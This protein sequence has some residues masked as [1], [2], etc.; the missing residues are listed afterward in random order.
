LVFRREEKPFGKSWE[1]WTALWWKWVLSK[2]KSDNPGIDET[3][4][5]FT[6]DRSNPYVVFMVGTFG[7]HSER[8][9]VLPAGM[10]ILFP[11]INFTTSYKE[12]PQL[13]SEADL[14]ARAKQDIDDIVNKE[15][16]IN[17]WRLKCL[18]KYRVQSQ[19]FDLTLPEDNVFGLEHG[20]T[21]AVSDGYWVFLK[22]LPKGNYDIHASGSCSLGKTKVDILWH[23]LAT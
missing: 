6:T 8:R 17:G 10:A 2:P 13:K 12:E 14:L 18:E 23:V 19:V 20:P 11:I 22:P 7:G 3:G 5:K 4:E 21:K 15:A 9:Y 16:I 1:E